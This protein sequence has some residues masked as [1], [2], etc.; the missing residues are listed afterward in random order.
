M[1]FPFKIKQNKTTKILALTNPCL[2]GCALGTWVLWLPVW[3]RSVLNPSQSG[4]EASCSH[5]A[6]C[7]LTANH[8]ALLLNCV[9]RH[10]DIKTRSLDSKT[11][12]KWKGL[13]KV[14][15]EAEGMER[16]P[17]SVRLN[18][19]KQLNAETWLYD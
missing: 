6:C 9:L 10:G 13:V 17:V 3:F 4:S 11:T 19:E 12:G 16:P 7:L 1:Y 15:M 18:F 5:F 2:Q 14:C 8:A